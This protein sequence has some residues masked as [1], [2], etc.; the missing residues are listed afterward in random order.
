ME[1]KIRELM[2]YIF[3]YPNGKNLNQ[4]NNLDRIIE[5]VE[6]QI[7]EEVQENINK[8]LNYILL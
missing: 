5:E 7:Q 3:K 2:T 8:Q 6:V 1:E 4:D